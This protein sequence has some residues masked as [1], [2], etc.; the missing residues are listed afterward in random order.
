VCSVLL[1]VVCVFV[2]V[3]VIGL[4]IGELPE[5]TWQRAP[6]FHG[7]GDPPHGATPLAPQ[8]MIHHCTFCGE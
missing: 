1:C 8:Y 3:Q 6:A 4:A 2:R 7:Q 5:Q